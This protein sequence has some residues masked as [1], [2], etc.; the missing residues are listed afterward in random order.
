MPWSYN[1]LGSDEWMFSPSSLFFESKISLVEKLLDVMAQHGEMLCALLRKPIMWS[2]DLKVKSSDALFDKEACIAVIF[3][4]LWIH[5]PYR[6]RY[7][8]PW[9]NCRLQHLIVPLN[10]SFPVHK[11]FVV[12]YSDSKLE[13]GRNLVCRAYLIA[14]WLWDSCSCLWILML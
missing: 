2:D 7:S 6:W 4:A 10:S 11:K 1:S 8:M 12:L 13:P 14:C 5:L 9:G 3:L